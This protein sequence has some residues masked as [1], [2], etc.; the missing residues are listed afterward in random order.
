MPK[1]TTVDVPSF[2]DE[3]I[4]AIQVAVIL[5]IKDKDGRY[6]DRKVIRELFNGDG[7]VDRGPLRGFYEGKTPKFWLSDV[8]AYARAQTEKTTGRP[9]DGP[10]FVTPRGSEKARP[11][12]TKAKQ[13]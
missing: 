10:A 4:T 9:F 12:P 1:A 11:K 6:N 8:L 5:K 7:K 13:R 3:I 2:G